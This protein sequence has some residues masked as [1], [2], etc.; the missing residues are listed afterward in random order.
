[1]SMPK[2]RT[3]F[4]GADFRTP[5]GEVVLSDMRSTPINYIDIPVDENG[6][7]PTHCAVRF[8]IDAG[9]SSSGFSTHPI[10]MTISADG[11]GTGRHQYLTG[12]GL[13]RGS[14]SSPSWGVK[15]AYLVIPIEPGMVTVATQNPEAADPG[16]AVPG[17]LKYLFWKDSRRR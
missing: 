9:S 16:A 15:S 17:V 6:D 11:A 12:D 2:V 7:G 3:Y 13:P 10:G 4:G 1:M 8:D 5:T 14:Y